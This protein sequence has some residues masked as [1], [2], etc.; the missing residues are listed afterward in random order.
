MKL[1]RRQLLAGLTALGAGLRLQGKAPSRAPSIL[2]PN[3]R[4]IAL[5]SPTGEPIE[6]WD[7]HTGERVRALVA[8]PDGLALGLGYQMKPQR[9]PYYVFHGAFFTGDGRHLVG[10]FKDYDFHGTCVL[11]VAGKVPTRA[12]RAWEEYLPSSRLELCCEGQA[13]VVMEE[14]SQVVKARTTI[15]PGAEGIHGSWATIDSH[16]MAIATENC[17]APPFGPLPEPRPITVWLWRWS[18]RV[19]PVACTLPLGDIGKISA[20]PDHRWIVV[21]HRHQGFTRSL[22][23]QGRTRLF[24][25]PG[26]KEFLPSIGEIQPCELAVDPARKHLVV[27]YG[28]G[29]VRVYELAS[30]RLLRLMTAFMPPSALLAWGKDSQRLLAS[31]PL[32]WASLWNRRG[33]STKAEGIN[34]QL[35]RPPITEIVSEIRCLAWSGELLLLGLERGTLMAFRPSDL[36]PGT[37]REPRPQKALWSIAGENASAR[38][39]VILPEAFAAL[40]VTGRLNLWSLS[41]RRLLGRVQ[42]HPLRASAMVASATQLFT[43]GH[44]GV[45]AWSLPG[46]EPRFHLDTD[47][48]WV[49]ALAL[50]LGSGTLCVGCLDGCIRGFSVQDGELR[51]KVKAHGGWVGGLSVSPVGVL[52]SGGEDGRARLW[53]AG[54][55]KALA[56]TEQGGHLPAWSPDGQWLAMYAQDRVRLLDKNL[57]F[58]DLPANHLKLDWGDDWT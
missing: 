50:D 19:Q 47:T 58:V 21:H 57:R 32:G 44:D 24:E 16:T 23:P 38:A 25:L 35:E 40:E 37:E 42:A 53:E 54:T 17:C 20:L 30:R 28:A 51:W 3:G 15:P 26:P 55:G 2:H 52:A 43:G 46:L 13:W 8:S 14:R 56:L 7:I 12:G 48:H 34:T 41:D 45:R 11:D 9:H 31:R 29:T 6:L 33:R 5:P 4:W 22:I 18:N 10:G 36:R 1:S 27:R 39:L 49:S